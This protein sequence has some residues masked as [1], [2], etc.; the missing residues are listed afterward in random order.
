[1]PTCGVERRLPT[2]AQD[3]IL[4]HLV[5]A[6]CLLFCAACDQRG[7][8]EVTVAA[9]ANLTGVFQIIGPKFETSSGI[10]PIFS[11]GSTA[12]LTQQIE[13][14]APYDVIAAADSAHVIQLEKRGLLLP[15]SRALYATGILALWIP[16][17]SK[18][19]TSRLEDLTLPGVRTIAVAKPELAPYGQAAV[20][21]LRQLGIWE[22]VKSKIVYAGNIGMAKQYG[23]SNNADAV[24][25]AYSLVQQSGGKVIQVDETLHQPITQELG[26][27]A[28]SKR[29]DA[30]HK[31][32]A[33]LLI[34]EGRDILSKSGY[35]VPPKPN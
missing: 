16:P 34:G 18:A 12:Q 28:A 5:L 35:R 17:G 22:R 23:S 19:V 1:M 30:A 7:R 26:I 15:G 32:V 20:D 31:F 6:A 10:H 14:S 25:T 21:T 8:P 27:V 3:A 13:N 9:A 33:F 29:Q 4:P 11:F 2:G 24:F